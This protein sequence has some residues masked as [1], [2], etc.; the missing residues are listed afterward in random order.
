[1]SPDLGDGT[2]ARFFA[3]MEN[4]DEIPW[5][6]FEFYSL[7]DGHRA[8]ELGYLEKLDTDVVPVENVEDGA[9]DE[10]GVQRSL[11]GQV[12]TWNTEKFPEDGPQP[13][14]AADF[15]DFEKFPGKRCAPQYSDQGM[16]EQALMADGVPHDEIYPLDV[17][18]AF[19]K[20]DELKGKVIFNVSPD[21]Q[22]QSL[23]SGECDVAMVFSGRV[24]NAVTVDNAPLKMTWNDAMYSPGYMGVP[25]GAPNK[26][27]GMALIAMYV[28]DV[29][30]NKAL[31]SKIPYPTPL[32]II[33]LDEYPAETQPW[34][35][36]GENVANALAKDVDYYDENAVE[37]DKRFTAWLAD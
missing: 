2:T 14:G 34:L 32:K 26:D 19:R 28:T 20:L 23:L 27:A 3:A 8:A 37:L 25:K 16:L 31:V 17:D 21:S 10:Y 4:G 24:Y 5:S 30:A 22:I 15:Y 35:P 6:F 33:P 36:V 7:N 13:E 1:V 29:E 12:L 11:F 18:R 9:Y